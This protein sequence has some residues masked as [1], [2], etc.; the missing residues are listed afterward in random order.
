MLISAYNINSIKNN[1]F[2]SEVLGADLPEYG[3][4]F[5]ISYLTKDT[6]IN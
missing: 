2:K 4:V 6:F 1:K 3:H 5:Y